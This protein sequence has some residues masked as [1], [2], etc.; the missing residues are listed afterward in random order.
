MLNQRRLFFSLIWMAALPGLASAETGRGALAA[1]AP[2]SNYTAGVVAIVFVIAFLVAALLG[3]GILVLNL[4]L[5]SKRDEDRAHQLNRE[6]GDP[7]ILKASVY[8][9]ER[10]LTNVFPAVDGDEWV[11]DEVVAEQVEVKPTAP[12][13]RAA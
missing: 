12:P 2:F 6:P 3:G 8:P 13:R 5:M 11:E 9:E 4:G 10:D 1:S 7:A